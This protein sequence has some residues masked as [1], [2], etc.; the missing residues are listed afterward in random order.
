MIDLIAKLLTKLKRKDLR[1]TRLGEVFIERYYPFIIAREGWRFKM[2]NVFFQHFN[3][4]IEDEFV[5]DHGRWCLSIIL[6]GGYTDIRADRTRI[7]RRWSVDT[8]RY[9]EFHQVVDIL[10]DTWTLFFVGRARQEYRM[11]LPNTDTLINRS[12]NRAADK[13]GLVGTHPETPELLA[14]I[15]KRQKAMAR[16]KK[17][18]SQV[19]KV[20]KI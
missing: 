17:L 15:K 9:D 10:P 20:I 3:S 18:R 16:L 4:E 8:L 11:K 1:I 5:H 19:L 2:P 12:T 7:R 14:Q 13:Q 6:R